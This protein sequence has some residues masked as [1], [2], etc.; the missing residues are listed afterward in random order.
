MATKSMTLLKRS[1]IQAAVMAAI[2][3]SSTSLAAKDVVEVVAFGRNA[4]G[5]PTVQT[6][7]AGGDSI[8][9]VVEALL[10]R[11]EAFSAVNNLPFVSANLDALG[12]SDVL[13][14]DIAESP[15]S[16][17]ARLRSGITDLDESFSG[18]TRDE[19]EE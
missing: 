18:A 6:A 16:V 2:G 10:Q 1:A 5:G 14:V 19:V 12:V 9:D 4:A 17:I 8:P 7:R 3:I 13:V 11:D 15:G